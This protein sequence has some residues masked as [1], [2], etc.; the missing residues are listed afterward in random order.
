MVAALP[1]LAAAPEPDGNMKWNKILK[2]SSILRAARARA[3]QRG[4]GRVEEREGEGEGGG[5]RTDNVSDCALYMTGTQSLGGTPS[6]S[7]AALRRASRLSTPDTVNMNCG[8]LRRACR[9]RRDG[10][11]TSDDITE[12][13]PPSR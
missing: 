10:H 7:W 8:P 2:I 13:T 9:T 5:G 3:L 11:M 1:L 6:S 12:A 4:R